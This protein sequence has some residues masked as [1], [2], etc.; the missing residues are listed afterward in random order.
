MGVKLFLIFI[1][2]LVVVIGIYA[3]DVISKRIKRYINC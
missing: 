3:E 2:I 1:L